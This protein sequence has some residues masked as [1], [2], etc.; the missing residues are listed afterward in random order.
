MVSWKIN[1]EVEGLWYSQRRREGEHG[2]RE[3]GR[4]GEKGKA[5]LAG[6]PHDLSGRGLFSREKL[7]VRSNTLPELVI[8]EVGRKGGRKGEREGVSEGKR[9]GEATRL[10][11]KEPS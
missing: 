3:G 4:E 6:V 8:D 7:E 10:R 5:R 9:E 1:N 2:G 11:D